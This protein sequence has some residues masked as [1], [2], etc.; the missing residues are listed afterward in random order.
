M[1]RTALI[2]GITGQDGAYLSQLLLEKGYTVHGTARPSSTDNFWRIA[3]FLD[4][5]HI[6]RADLLDQGSLIRLLDRCQPDE[7]YNLAAMSYVPTSFEQPLLTGEVTALGVARMLEAIRIIK[8]DIRFYQASSS[9]MFGATKDQT[10]DET[11]AFHPRSPYGIAKCYGHW[12]TVNYREAYGIYGCS[13]IL[14]NHESPLRGEQFV[15]RKITLAAARIK[16]GLQEKLFLGNLEARRDWGYA[17]DYVQA[18]WQMLQQEEPSDY[19]IGTGQQHSVQ[20]FAEMAFE[21]VGLDWKRYVEIDSSLLRPTDVVNL[22]GNAEKAKE[23]LGW[24]PKVSCKELAE[25]MVEADLARLSPKDQSNV[26][27]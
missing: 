23:R 26:S 6:H 15:T 24:T 25:I 20:Q 22:C 13:G 1:T 21:K 8:P 12:T 27:T 3:P 18:M 2:T 11:T 7:V 4:R 5:L 16:L 19:V 10:Q 14:F 17:A 9:E